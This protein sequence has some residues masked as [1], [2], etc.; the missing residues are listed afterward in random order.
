MLSPE[1]G[2][3]IQG[4]TIKGYTEYNINSTKIKGHNTLQK[5][6]EQYLLDDSIIRVKLLLRDGVKMKIG[7]LHKS[8][9]ETV[10]KG[11]RKKGGGSKQQNKKMNWS[12][13]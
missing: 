8:I 13:E 5:L 1:F 6:R 11:K 4:Y 9:H 3:D 7:S 2:Q 10:Q 12:D